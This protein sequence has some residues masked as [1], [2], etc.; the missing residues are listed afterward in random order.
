MVV[1]QQ[2]LW[3]DE[4]E[5]PLVPIRVLGFRSFLR[6]LNWKYI[7]QLSCILKQHRIQI[8]ESHFPDAHFAGALAARFAGIPVVLSCRRDLVD[9]YSWKKL[10]LCKLGNRF[11]T[12]HLANSQAVA[13]VT[14]RVEGMRQSQ[15]KVIHNGVDLEAF[16]RPSKV[17]TTLEFKAAA[18]RN[19]IIVL[20]A[21][22]L[23]IKNIPMFVDAA[24]IVAEQHD[25]VCF[26]VIG[27][28]PEEERLKKMAA[29]RG[30]KDRLIWTGTVSDIRP[31]LKQATIGCLSSD[32][33]GFSNSVLEYM[34]AGLPVVATRVGGA[35][36]AVI[37][38]VT[39]YLIRKGDAQQMASRLINLLSNPTGSRAMGFA[40]RQRAKECFS[41]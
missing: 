39:G 15:I 28:G 8:V 9:Q 35:S 22:L 34:A 20:A 16:M 38:G 26:A 3:T 4:F 23:P 37:D 29:E 12:H 32:S 5:D 13:A 25:D 11:A 27:S 1:L 10:A 18:A 31:Y 7:W 41:F 40:S 30:V 24:S 36:E 17:S 21:N 14:S 6:P 2:S 33:E 19:R